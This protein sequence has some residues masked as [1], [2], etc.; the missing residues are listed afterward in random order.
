VGYY[1]VMYP[2]QNVEA[3]FW[4]L[5]RDGNWGSVSFRNCHYTFIDADFPGSFVMVR[6]KATSGSAQ[7]VHG[8]YQYSPF[9]FTGCP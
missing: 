9:P 1:K 7:T 5:L 3:E 4:Y 8:N 2:E 6:F